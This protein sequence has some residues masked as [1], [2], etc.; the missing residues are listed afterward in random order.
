MGAGIGKHVRGTLMC[1][2]MCLCVGCACRH[3]MHFGSLTSTLR[4]HPQY[5]SESRKAL[6]AKAEAEQAAG[7]TPG[8][9]S[10]K[11]TATGTPATAVRPPLRAL[12][13]AGEAPASAPAKL[14]ARG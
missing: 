13:L 1:V 12:Q 9:N 3:Y 10:Q 2:F 4:V 6:A 5:F 14:Q 7:G 8:A 11:K